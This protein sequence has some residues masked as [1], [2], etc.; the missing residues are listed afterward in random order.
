MVG[1]LPIGIFSWLRP[2][3]PVDDGLKTLAAIRQRGDAGMIVETACQLIC[4]LDPNGCVHTLVGYNN[5]KYISLL[6]SRSLRQKQVEEGITDNLCPDTMESYARFVADTPI[7]NEPTRRRLYWFLYGLILM[8][9]EELA[10]HD[11]A[12]QPSMVAI[13]THLNECRDIIDNVLRANV[14]WT[15]DEKDV[16]MRNRRQRTPS[17]YL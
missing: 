4:N 13:W 2:K 1:S 16:G 6:V 9:T 12:H 11:S 8:K 17:I 3:R 7:P 5:V 15:D 10:E 14:L